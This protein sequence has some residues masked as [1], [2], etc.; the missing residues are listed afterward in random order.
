M[1]DN[2]FCIIMAGGVGS[3]FW[4]VSRTNKPKQFLDILDTGQSLLQ[5]TYFRFRKIL[6]EKNILIV[7]NAQYKELIKEQLKHISEDQILC[8]PERRNTA[9]CI[10]YALFKI[11]TKN[12]TAKMVV[13]PADHLIKAEEN[14][15]QLIRKGLSIVS[16]NNIL[17]T[18][19]IR[20]DKP[21]T[22]Y[23][24]IQMH[25]EKPSIAEEGLYKVKTFTEKP[26]LEMAE[27][28]LKSGDFLWNAGIFMWSAKTILQ[29][30]ENYLPEVFMLF[31]EGREL[32]NT[33]EED[34]FIKKT[35]SKCINISIDYGIMEKADNTYVMPGN[36][37]WSDLGNWSAIYEQTEKDKQQ[38]AVMGKD[39]F[40][41]NS[42]NCLVK[43]PA[44]KIVVAE[45]LNDYIIV[46]SENMLLI[47]RKKEEQKIKD[48]LQDI[49]KQKGEEYL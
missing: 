16:E 5:Q 23:G 11:L 26:N 34:A 42:S 40:L 44:N 14:F 28:F 7:T 47:C 4:P 46:E 10:A 24:Y 31:N 39:V 30:F 49:K 12:P 20:P 25:K 37:G 17:C 43:M 2:Y 41:Y 29:A 21:E 1:N 15:L 33:K 22:G 48:F 36:F 9:P 6:P 13:T 27:L 3:R 18:I 35:Y 45:G 32:F 8:E 38:N 19:G